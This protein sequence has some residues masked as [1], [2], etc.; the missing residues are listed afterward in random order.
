MLCSFV[1]EKRAL[2]IGIILFP[3]ISN[4]L[5]LTL[6]DPAARQ[7][8]NNEAVRHMKPSFIGFGLLVLQKRR[9]L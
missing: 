7:R 5:I 3:S 8:S 2:I 4:E 1:G 6:L 9:L